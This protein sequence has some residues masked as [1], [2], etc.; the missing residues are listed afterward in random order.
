MITT[1]KSIECLP[2]E[3]WLLFMIF[4]PPIDLYRAL[5]GLN[6]RINYL[7]S[8]MTPRPVLDTSQCAGDRICFSDLL[9]LIEGK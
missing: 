2:N 9:Q 5:A 1:M 3:L 4:L 6:H 7:L 8:S